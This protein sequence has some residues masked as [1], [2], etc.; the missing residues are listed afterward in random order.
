[1]K[2]EAS[3]TKVGGKPEITITFENEGHKRITLREG[4][5]YSVKYK[6]NAKGNL[7]GT[8]DGASCVIKGIGHFKDTL[9][10]KAFTVTKTP[11]SELK[12]GT[13]GKQYKA[14]KTTAYYATAPVIFDAE[15]KQLS[16]GKDFRIKEYQD[17]AGKVIQKTDAVSSG[18]DSITL[19][20]EG[21]G[22]FEGELPVKCRVSEEALTKISMAS[23]TRIPVQP[24][25]GDAV[26]PDIMLSIKGKGTLT[27]NRNYKILGYYNNVRK[28][29]AMILVQGIGDYTGTKTITFKI[30]P[31]VLQIP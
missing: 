25:T 28:G 7:A 5:D 12:F 14:G 23:V 16:S 24:Y 20:L 11:L 29:T 19:I 13:E 18:T 10:K 26:T 9:P 4:V 17:S 6:N 27:E 31:A 30:G 15:G 3:F 2:T 21:I 8:K 22:G 1:M